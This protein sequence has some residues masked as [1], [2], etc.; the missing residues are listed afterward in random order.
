MKSRE[1]A[2][3]VESYLKSK[4]YIDGYV[5]FAKMKGALAKKYKSYE[6]RPYSC[7]IGALERW[8]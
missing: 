2:R 4:R 6:D 5:N 3:T 7:L 8:P 1:K